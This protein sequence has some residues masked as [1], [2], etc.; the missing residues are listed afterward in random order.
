MLYR[1]LGRTGCEVSVLGFGCMRF[2]IIG[3]KS[4]VDLFDPCK[5]IDEAAAS[6]VRT[7]QWFDVVREQEALAG[8][9]ESAARK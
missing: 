8:R 9:A 2:P 3:G 5:P 4:A 1:K 6:E 7:W